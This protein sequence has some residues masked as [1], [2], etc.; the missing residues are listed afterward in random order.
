[1][2]V[3]GVSLFLPPAVR[4]CSVYHFFNFRNVGLSGIQSVRYRNEQ[5]CRCRNQ[6]GTEIRAP[7][8]VTECSGTG[9]RYR[10]PECQYIPAYFVS[11][12]MVL[13]CTS[14][15]LASI[16]LLPDLLSNPLPN[17]P[18]QGR[19]PSQSTSTHRD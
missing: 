3:Q 17:P 16:F 15:S 7:G 2:D 14:V 9:L 1:M 8:P 12:K 11:G 13:F 18:Y 19:P 4:T 5:K 10:M 6:S